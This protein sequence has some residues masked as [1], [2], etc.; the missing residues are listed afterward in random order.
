MRPLPTVLV[1]DRGQLQAILAI[2]SELHCPICLRV[3][4]AVTA[5][6]GPAVARA[7]V[8]AAFA[9]QAVGD[10]RSAAREDASVL[11]RSEWELDCGDAAGLALQALR[12]GVPRIRIDVDASVLA[13]LADIAGR[14]NAIVVG[15]DAPGAGGRPDFLDL[16]GCADA[17]AA[18][19]RWLGAMMGKYR[20][21]DEEAAERPVAKRRRNGYPSAG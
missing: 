10:G 2:A 16:S 4:F 14:R 15:D 11:Q 8:G 20:G 5:G 1:Y 19:R 7:M 21:E 3:P 6:L 18:C 12:L 9:E 13:K 17:G